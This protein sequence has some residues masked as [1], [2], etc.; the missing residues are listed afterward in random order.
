MVTVQHSALLLLAP[1]ALLLVLAAARRGGRPLP[2]WRKVGSTAVRALAVF[3]LALTLA[4]PGVTVHAPLDVFTVFLVDVSESVPPAAQEAAVE[5]VRA[6]WDRQVAA[7]RR[8]ALVAFA[9]RARVLVPASG[10]PWAV[11]PSRLAP[12]V[13]LERLRAASE[14]GDAHAG[15][16]VEDLERWMDSVQTGA[17]HLAEALAV[18]RG[19]FREGAT[20]RIVLLTDGLD[21]AR[22][23]AEI[24]LPPGTLAV[25][26]SDPDWNDLAVTGVEAP[27]AVRAGEPFDVRVTLSAPAAG[28]VALSLS[29]DDE[30]FPEARR[31]VTVAPGRNSVVLENVQQ[32]RTLSPGLRRIGVRADLPGDPEPRNNEGAAAV[33]VTGKPRVLLV[34]ESPADG[35][36]IARLLQAQDIEFDRETPARLAARGGRFEEFVAVILAG[37]PREALGAETVRALGA[38]V[39]GSGGGLWVVGSPALSGPRG[40][41]GSEIEKLLPVSFLEEPPEPGKGPDPAPKPAP[42]QP[43]PAAGTPQ[44]VLAP[45]L[46]LLFVVDKS[47]SMAGNNIAL[48]KEACLATSKTLT[49]RDVVGVLGFD[50]KPKWV[51]EF[52]DA[53]R[54]DYIED[55][56]MRLFADGGTHIYPALVETLQA[57]K[58]DPRARNASIKHAILLSDGDTLPADFETVVRQMAEEGI[59]VTSVCVGSA[60]KFDAPLMSQIATWG[61]GRFLFTSSFRKVPQLF[62]DDVRKILGPVRDAAG[63]AAPPPTPPPPPPPPPPE[64]PKGGGSTLVPVVVRQPHEILQGI[65]ARSLPPLHGRLGAAAREKVD[66]PLATP[67]GR[68]VLALRRVGL[69]K[70]AVWT[71]DL[72]GPWSSDWMTWPGSA[73]LFAQLVRYVSSAAPD[74]EL[75]ARLHVKVDGARAHVRLDPGPPGE[76]LTVLDLEARRPIPP[77]VEPDG[78]AS[79]A[80]PLERAGDMKR[81]LIQ[82]PDG[83]QLQVGAVRSYD[84][85]LS[86]PDPARDLFAGGSAEARGWAELER[87]L[88]GARMS[89]ERRVDLSLWGILAVL[90]LLPLDVALRRFNA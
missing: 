26:L 12:R 41:A 79:Y 6:A 62:L 36:A 22:R 57:F 8:C 43:A 64:P 31:E 44:R 27:T 61:K 47:G 68:P 80:L 2:R 82:R 58:T 34:Q 15:A 5:K 81:A 13:A 83:K 9:G 72:G 63:A 67:D 65:E 1:A 78:G 49:A 76:S 51:L 54:Q 20:N 55:R 39:D 17:T 18:A 7:G 46:A 37:V 14:R 52:T 25:R 35:E 87:T 45:T 42:P 69:G 11:D 60:P 86:P 56:V 77:S 3:V 66:V 24:D 73:K 71:S 29:I 85:E 88:A 50:V 33:T 10:Q 75:A 40:Y 38:Y 16:A 30:G 74:A 53:D 70:T 59:T 19:L 21:T 48:V 89:G 28:R 23:A 4:R 84:A 90:L 32:K